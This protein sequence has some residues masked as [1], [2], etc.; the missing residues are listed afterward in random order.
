MS[1]LA[2][3]GSERRI[4]ITLP[5]SFAENWLTHHIADFYQSHS[6][7]DLRLDAT[8]RMVD[9]LT[10]DFDFALRYSLPSDDSFEEAV[11]FGDYVL[12]LC[13]PDFAERYTLSPGL[14]S[15]EGVPLVHLDNRTPDPEWADWEMW[16]T[17]HGFDPAP[18]RRGVHY[19]QVSSGLQAART[20]Q[21]LVL[22]GATE[23]FISLCEGNLVMP[24]GP[25]MHC[26]TG[27]K[28]RLVWLKDRELS[29]LQEAFRRWL[30]QE[31]EVFS[32]SVEK[33]LGIE[34]VPISSAIHC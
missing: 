16:G 20:G 3:A 14:R 23:A 27:Y 26:Q 31:A 18:L 12:P 24:F 21:G 19:T 11:L 15:L 13:S 25:Q 29:G 22:C 9:L 6:S 17:A 5:A 2:D 32:A 34:A 28:Y 33:L 4:S 30:L 1:D 10:E 7:V 8:N